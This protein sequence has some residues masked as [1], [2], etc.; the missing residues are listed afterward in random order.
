MAQSG[1]TIV[2]PRTGQT[3]TFRQTARDTGGRL[4]QIDCNNAPHGPREPEHIHP[5]QESR[6]E[7]FSG[8]LRVSSGG[9]ERVVGPGEVM[10]IPPRTP[11]HFWV[12]G[13]ATA[14]YRQEFR[15]ALHIEQFFETLFGLARDGRLDERGMPLPLQLAVMVREFG[16]EIRPTSL[17]WPVLRLL[18]LLLEPLA[19][20]RGY[21]AVYPQY[22]GAVPTPT[23]GESVHSRSSGASRG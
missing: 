10:T 15:P 20:W 1:E 13:D 6:M 18:A 23:F 9:V 7:V 16:D 5:F 14:Q 3:M 12:E 4:L 21:R 19:R 2:N 8:A 22:S 17:P 11:H